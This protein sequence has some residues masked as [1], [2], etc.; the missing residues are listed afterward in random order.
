MK[1]GLIFSAVFLAIGLTLSGCYKDNQPEIELGDEIHLFYPNVENVTIQYLGKT[2]SCQKINGKFIFQGDIIVGNDAASTKAAEMAEPGWNIQLW[3]EGK[4]Y[5]VITENADNQYKDAVSDAM[6]HISTNTNVKFIEL[7]TPIV[8]MN[9][10]LEKKSYIKFITTDKGNWSYVGMLSSEQKK[11]MGIEKQDIMITD[12]KSGIVIHELGHALGLMHEHSRSDRDK[13]VEITVKEKPWHWFFMTEDEFQRNIMQTFEMGKYS[14]FDFG[15]IM[16]YPPAIVVKEIIRKKDGT[17]YRDSYQRT[18]LSE[19]DIEAI[20]K[21]YPKQIVSPDII[22]NEY[23][24]ELIND[25]VYRATGELIYEGDPAITERGIQYGKVNGTPTKVAATGNTETFTCDLTNL[26]L[27][28]A[29]FAEAYV[30]QNGVTKLSNNRILF[31]TPVGLTEDIHNII[32]DDI[33]EKFIELGI[34]INGGNN[35]PNVEGAYFVSPL[36]LIKSN[37]ADSYSPGYKFADMQLTFSKQDNAKLTVVCDY[38]NG[39]QIGSGLGSFITGNGN[40]FS[41]F[42]EVSGTFSGYPFK[43]VEI[44]SGEITPSGIKDY[45]SAIMITEEA[46]GTIKRGQGRL[47]YDSDGSSERTTQSKATPT[48][49]STFSSGTSIISS[50]QPSN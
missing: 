9:W 35:P 45:Y 7:K 38:I 29:Y 48:L 13:Y 37:F 19:K 1:K 23:T 4:I 14:E 49:K 5:Y 46:P 43:S 8:Q 25:N 10:E 36:I 27:N 44:Y 15:S 17:S 32:P 26:E 21:M 31:K 12:T 30:V 47:I 11:A 22:I 42:T 18:R 33:L 40:K 16:M 39:T 3:W 24:S 6:R 20:N 50:T 2:I 34:E 28:T 41:V